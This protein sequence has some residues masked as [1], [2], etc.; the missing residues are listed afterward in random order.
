MVSPCRTRIIGWHGGPYD[1]LLSEDFYVDSR[2][3]SRKNN[4]T[5]IKDSVERERE[6]ELFQ[7]GEME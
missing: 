7:L 3:V 1:Q 4:T 6:G 5:R 2:R